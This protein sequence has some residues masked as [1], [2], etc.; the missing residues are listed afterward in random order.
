MMKQ[1]LSNLSQMPV[2]KVPALQK[3]LDPPRSNHNP[4][5][6]ANMSTTKSEPEII[7]MP[8]QK[9]QIDEFDERPA[10]E[11]TIRRTTSQ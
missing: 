1:H 5:S 9:I 7:E 4:G 8:A 10:N 6:I 3:E 11:T 2:Q